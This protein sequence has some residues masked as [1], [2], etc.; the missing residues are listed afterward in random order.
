MSAGLRG[1]GWWLVALAGCEYDA[2]IVTNPAHWQREDS[3]AVQVLGASQS[4]C[5]GAG[6]PIALSFALT[7]DRGFPIAAG[8]TLE[9]AAGPRVQV[10]PGTLAVELVGPKLTRTDDASAIVELG[11]TT[12]ESPSFVPTRHDLVTLVVDGSAQASELDP[13]GERLRA[14]GLAARTYLSQPVEAAL[15]HRVAVVLLARGEI[16]KKLPPDSSIPHAVDAVDSMAAAEGGDARLFDGVAE[17]AA[18]TRPA[19]TLGGAILLVGAGFQ[20]KG[21]QKTGE[22]VS[23]ELLQEPTVALYAVGLEDDATWRSL[24]CRSG[25]LLV[26][27]TE[28]KAL[29]TTTATLALAVGGRFTA[30]LGLPLGLAAATYRLS[31]TLRITL[32]EGQ[33]TETRAVALDVAVDVMP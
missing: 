20:D 7:D 6:A 11:D 16:S 18:Q 12:L 25:G 14:A 5:T 15:P 13:T 28:P 32:G 17:A 29:A 3:A 26:S 31:G 23:V 22:A 21:S 4:P 9:L 27:V 10:G 8:T 1:I 33:T 24:S 2:R 30:T 19:T